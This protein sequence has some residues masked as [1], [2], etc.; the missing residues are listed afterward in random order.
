VPAEVRALKGWSHEIRTTQ[1][2]GAECKRNRLIRFG[3]SSLSGSPMAQTFSVNVTDRKVVYDW[4][5]FPCF[6][7]LYTFQGVQDAH[8]GFRI[9]VIL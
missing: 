6:Y 1:H 5:C 2:K 8:W 3:V 4:S 9:K 7:Y